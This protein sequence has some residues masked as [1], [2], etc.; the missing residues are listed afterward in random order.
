[1]R[2][3]EITSSLMHA[4]MHVI[5]VCVCVCVQADGLLPFPLTSSPV[6]EPSAFF[7]LITHI[8]PLNHSQSLSHSLSLLFSLTSSPVGELFLSFSLALTLSLVLLLV[9]SLSV[10]LALTLLVCVSLCLFLSLALTFLLFSFTSCCNISLPVGGDAV[11]FVFPPPNI[12][13]IKC[14][15]R[16]NEFN[17]FC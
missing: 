16:F 7:S 14:V 3:S 2:V 15:F 13:P 17:A 1:M 12:C 5:C 9:S 6:G 8:L 11:E 4:F 10:S